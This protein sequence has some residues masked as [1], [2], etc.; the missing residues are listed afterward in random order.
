MTSVDIRIEGTTVM[1]NNEEP[2]AVGD[3]DFIRFTV[4]TKAWRMPLPELAVFVKK[5]G[6]DGVELPV[7]PGYQVEPED[8]ARGLPKAARTLADQGLV[9]GS[10]AGPTDE[11]TIA[12][13]AEAGVPI[14]RI[15]VGI[16][17]DCNYLEYEDILRRE[18]DELVPLLDRYGVTLGI[19]NHCDR[20]VANALGIRSLIRNYDPSHIGAVLDLAH[21]ALNGEV[22]SLALDIAWPHLRM[23]NLK[24]VIWRRVNGPEAEVASYEAYWTS[25]RQGLSPWATVVSELRRRRYRGTVCLTAEYS[26]ES[27]ADRLIA[28]DIVYARSLFA[29]A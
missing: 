26:D 25:G 9:I 2:G 13:C 27:A 16:P 12:A 28:E 15:C 3:D 23:V 29:N 19:Q 18:Y 22:P 4:F 10:V 6:F 5:L 21:C 11:A 24:N 14:I 7:R 17:D 1:V 8:V 20:C